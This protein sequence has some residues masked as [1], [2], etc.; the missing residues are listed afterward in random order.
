MLRV[1][2]EGTTYPDFN[3]DKMPVSEAIALEKV[4][5]LTPPQLWEGVNRFSGAALL[6]LVWLVR[7]RAEGA[8]AP[9][10]SQLEFDLST[11]DMVEV[12]D[13]GRTVTRDK[14]TGEVTHLDGEPVSPMGD[15]PDPTRPEEGTSSVG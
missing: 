3:D 12:D 7:R 1:T 11:F 2:V 15:T 6:A 14:K 4:S 5:G 10:Y 9:R 13:A 8:D